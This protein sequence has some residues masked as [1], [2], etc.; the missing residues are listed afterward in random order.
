MGRKKKPEPQEQAA[1]GS[2]QQT[3]PA[4]GG[5][6]FEATTEMSGFSSAPV[7]NSKFEVPA[8]FKQ[9]EADVN[10]RKR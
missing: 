8:G 5:M 9:V 4:G 7:D 10:K 2:Q 6:L 1:G 3:A